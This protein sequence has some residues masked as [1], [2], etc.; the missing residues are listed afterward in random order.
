MM[1]IDEKPA[2]ELQISNYLIH[3]GRRNNFDKLANIHLPKAHP[4]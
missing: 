3:D 2:Q 4:A 1:Q